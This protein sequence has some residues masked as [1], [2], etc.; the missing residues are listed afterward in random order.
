MNILIIGG[1][2]RE[3]A[4]AWKL[5]KSDRV[6]KIYVAPGNGGTASGSLIIENIDLNK[7][8]E[9]I[10]F[11]KKNHIGL[12]V[13]GPEVPL[14]EGIVDDFQK[15]NLKIFGPSK[16]AAQLESSKE[17]AKDF[18]HRH[19][20][21][22]ASYQ[23]FTD[24]NKAKEYVKKNRVPIVIKAD[25]LA[26]GKGV[27][28]AENEPEAFKAL[29]LMLIDN[30]FGD[31]GARV[32][33]EEYLEGEEA[34]FIVIS[35]GDS[36]LPLASSQ[37][38]KRLL[39]NDVGPNT[40]GM[41]AYS[42]A[43]IV[44]EDVHNKIMAQVIEP[45]IKGMKSDGINF[46]GF[47]YAGLMIDKNNNIKTLEFNCRMG[48]P[49]T[50]PILFRLKSD[51]LPVLLDATNNQLHKSQIEWEDNSSIT[52][53]MASKNYPDQ[54]ELGDIIYGLDSEKLSTNTFIFHAGTT[55]ENGKIKTSGGR[56]LGVTAKEKSLKEAKEKVYQLVK[57]IKFNGAQYRKDIAN[58][59]LK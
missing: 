46:C 2:G 41:G 34:S 4:L 36:I 8:D 42:P 7:T 37:D 13:V 39:D 19:N 23:T 15:N 51:L 6:R 33:I 56:V 25:G 53:V 18:M 54:P 58:K 10:S 40:G 57:K 32:V 45:T 59:A 11:A 24:L 29:E 16:A 20:I 50:Q 55:L 17:F 48:D 1:G 5:A 12:T 21:P 30:A 31:S 44:T 38:H 28:I 49:E 3:H 43:P 26:A 52:V 22:T 9:L 27:I 14:S 47:L 35:D